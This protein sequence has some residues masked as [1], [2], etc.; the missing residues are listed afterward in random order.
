MD[1]KNECTGQF[2]GRFVS[3]QR[4]LLCSYVYRLAENVPEMY[5]K[6]MTEIMHSMSLRSR[7]LL[8]KWVTENVMARDP[9]LSGNT[10][11]R[12]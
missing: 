9:I 10:V 1:G 2:C 11:E 5:V 3:S 12:N 7:E 6:C 4:L 8:K